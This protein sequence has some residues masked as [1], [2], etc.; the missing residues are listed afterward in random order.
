[1]NPLTS[2]LQ[3]R[4]FEKGEFTGIAERTLQETMALILAYPWT[5][6]RDHFVV[7]LT[8]PGVT[9]QDNRGNY[10]KLALYYNGKY[11]AYYCYAAGRLYQKAFEKPE[12]VTDAVTAFFTS[13]DNPPEGFLFQ[14]SF[15]QNQGTHFPTRNFRYSIQDLSFWQLISRGGTVFHIFIGIFLIATVIP[16][17]RNYNSPATQGFLLVLF[18][19]LFLIG[20]GINL[21]LLY[22]YY[23]ADKNTVIILSKGLPDFYFGNEQQQTKYNK[24]DIQKIELKRRS[25]RRSPVSEFAVY[26]ICM[27][28]GTELR[29]TS[30]LIPPDQ[31]SE[32]M[33]KVQVKAVERFAWPAFR[34]L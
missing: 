9:V 5:G 10:L 30:L 16:G 15:F 23:M 18:L 19:I 17:I 34:A 11:I 32:K 25:N 21:F 26:K 24:Q 33:H 8:G 7:G 12:D 4:D 29:F 3:Y 14:K 13:S 22:R 27:T 6:Q 31:L 28:N 2:K 20:G 1:M